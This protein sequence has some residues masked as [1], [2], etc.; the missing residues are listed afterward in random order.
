MV[1]DYFRNEKAQVVMKATVEM[2]K[3]LGLK[4]VAEGV[5][6]E[7]QIEGIKEL[8]IDYIQ[9]F[10]FAKPLPQKDYIKFIETKNAS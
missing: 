5:E 3:Q 9:G 6:T 7:K 1:Q 10:Y 2:I 8:G 4:I